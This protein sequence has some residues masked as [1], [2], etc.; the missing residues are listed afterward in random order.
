MG[1]QTLLCAI[2]LEDMNLAV[3]PRTR[4]V[5][6]NSTSPNIASSI[7][8]AEINKLRFYIYMHQKGW[9]NSNWRQMPKNCRGRQ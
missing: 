5:D 9:E 6:V 3:I 4:N 8:T 1:D 2:A 7:V